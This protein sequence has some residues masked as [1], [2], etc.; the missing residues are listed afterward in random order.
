MS[1]ELGDL[2]RLHICD[3]CGE[4]FATLRTTGTRMV[5]RCENDHEWLGFRLP[6][7]RPNP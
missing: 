7:E 6:D 1:E 2:R 4:E 5:Y 3:T